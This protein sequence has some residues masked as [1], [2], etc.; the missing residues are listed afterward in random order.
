MHRPARRVRG[1]G[2]PWWATVLVAG[3]MGCA[4]G[5][6]NRAPTPPVLSLESV[7]TTVDLVAVIEELSSDPEGERITYAYRW[8]V[9]GVNASGLETEV[10]PAERTQRGQT[11]EVTVEASD[12]NKASTG[13]LSA[14]ILNALPSAT[15]SI[16]PAGAVGQQALLASAAVSD[17]DG[18][19]VSLVWS[20]TVDGAGAGITG[21]TVDEGRTSHGEVWE[22]RAI[23]DDGL[24]AGQ[25]SLASVTIGN[26]P[27]VIHA[28]TLEPAAPR[29]GDPIV[30]VVSS[31]DP[32]GDARTPTC[33]WMVQDEVV[34]EGLCTLDPVHTAR[35]HLV[36]VDVVVDDGLA[37]SL[38]MSAEVVVEN[39]APSLASA[40]IDPSIPTQH[41]TVRVVPAGAEDADD[42]AIQYGVIWFVDGVARS[43]EGTHALAGYPQGS[44]VFARITPS[45]DL[46][47]GGSV[48]TDPVV[49]DNSAPEV[50]DVTITPD[51]VYEA[52]VVEAVVDAEDLDGDP[53][54]VAYTWRVDGKVVHEGPVSS[55]SGT[56]FDKGQL[57]DLEVTVDDG[58]GPSAPVSAS[59]RLVSNTPPTLDRVDLDAEAID[60]SMVV[61]CIP[62]TSADDDGDAVT[63]SWVWK[64]NGLLAATSPTID[65]S[66][67]DR[68]DEVV[69]SATPND[70]ETP[71]SPVDSAP[72]IVGNAPPEAPSV[73]IDPADPIWG[74]DTLTCV[75]DDSVTDADGDLAS[76]EMR[77]TVDGEPHAG[78]LGTFLGDTIPAAET[79]AGRT[80]SCIAV[81]ED[82]LGATDEGEAIEVTLAD[83]NTN[84]LLLVA[85]DVGLDVLPMYW[86][87][88]EPANT[89][90][91]DDLMRNG[92]TFLNAYASPGSAAARG[93][94]FTGRHPRRFGASQ[95]LAVDAL[96]GWGF[97]ETERSLPALL[98]EL[99]WDTALVGAWNLSAG[100]QGTFHPGRAGW[101]RY[102][103]SYGELMAETPIDDEASK[104]YY[105][106]VKND[107]GALE[108][109]TD[110][111]ATI[112]TVDDA[113]EVVDTL[114]EPWLMVVSFN[115]G[116]EPYHLAPSYLHTD[117]FLDF[118]SEPGRKYR[119][120]VEAMDSEIGRLLDDM[121]GAVLSRTSVVFLSDDGTPELVMDPVRAVPQH[122]GNVFEGGSNVPLVVSG[123]LVATPGL[124]TEALVQ[125]ED[126]F[127]TIRA[128][129]GQQPGGITRTDLLG[130][131]DQPVPTDGMSFLPVLA[132][133]A[134]S[135]RH[136]VY[137]ER[138]GPNGLGPYD[139]ED[140]RAVFDGRFKL[141]SLLIDGEL[142]ERL[143]DLQDVL[144]EGE[145]LLLGELDAEQAAAYASL[146]AALDEVQAMSVADV[147]EQRP[148][149]QGVTIDPEVPVAGAPVRCSV[150]WH[151]DLHLDEV[152]VSYAWFVEEVPVLEG[153]DEDVLDP[154]AFGPGELVRCEATPFD[155]VL[156][157]ESQAAEAVIGPA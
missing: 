83:A 36:S 97:P 19:E 40:S 110:R 27:P 45:D 34:L 87:A 35:D 124:Q 5:D 74:Y 75:P 18:D 73:H 121:D 109:L 157:G 82:V 24:Q 61:G 155:G 10:V 76:I 52:T 62:G 115:A 9:D 103:G 106:W 44:E 108:M 145:D 32:D 68:G 48:D 22:V 93:S 70:L 91:I 134:T 7:D 150:A 30:A 72:V 136:T 122:R 64:V 6:T 142:D 135:I 54:E 101:G 15:V 85:E 29:T 154:A 139:E 53:L 38:L 117:D 143:F 90:V 2:H 66:V 126:V 153:P 11:W 112:E 47:A 13:S 14:R 49:V 42:D 26:R 43:V 98:G 127:A 149:L 65:G 71:G 56:V 57:I 105:H 12:G 138:F 86:Q 25:P 37:D 100:W 146:A 23:P 130:G 152:T 80:W 28:V 99:G 16:S 78:S 120:M 79:V 94:M 123:P 60:A 3:F 128:I 96:G 102:V 31:S 104:G 92:L 148:A 137:V 95:D 39:T 55:I 67:F 58:G 144:V 77:W 147:P 151:G 8:T 4:D 50:L 59:P 129:A 1:R 20:W 81:A 116:A 107:Q 118:D 141:M 89:P 51:H 125:L 156:L 113:L 111:Y 132:D 119:A 46:D 21:P 133:R 84:V 41:D 63:V 114:A 33:T 140:A 17:P 88:D 69:C 131:P